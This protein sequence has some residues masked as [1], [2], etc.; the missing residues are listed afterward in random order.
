MG[1]IGSTQLFWL[2]PS[3]PMVSNA[4]INGW[5]ILL[6]VRLQAWPQRQRNTLA[7][8]LVLPLCPIS[9]VPHLPNWKNP[10]VTL[11]GQSYC[12]RDPISQLPWCSGITG[13][14]LAWWHPHQ[15]WETIPIPS[16]ALLI[17]SQ[18]LK[19]IIII[20]IEGNVWQQC[21]ALKSKPKDPSIWKIPIFWD[22]SE[23]RFTL[24]SRGPVPTAK[25]LSLSLGDPPGSCFLLKGDESSVINHIRKM[26]F[27]CQALTASKSNADTWL[28]L[29]KVS[30]ML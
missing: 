27:I 19:I 8:S 3:E 15:L 24:W 2:K 11:L 10:L 7:D 20:T 17:F 21:Q 5:A 18:K 4:D 12:I 22:F 26:C 16:D 30:R 9:L 23:F 28:L 25:R 13:G 29:S 1:T 14:N 6:L